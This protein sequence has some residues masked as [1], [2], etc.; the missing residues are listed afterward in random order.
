MKPLEAYTYARIS[1]K[2]TIHLEPY[3]LK[4][5]LHS[6]LYA[7]NIIKGRWKEAES[8]IFKDSWLRKQ[9]CDKFIKKSNWKNG[10]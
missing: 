8:I 9:Y 4:S 3:I 1:K 6:Y 10:F 5:T 7:V 2:R